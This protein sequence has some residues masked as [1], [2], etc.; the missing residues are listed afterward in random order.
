MLESGITTSHLM[1]FTYEFETQLLYI[2]SLD[3]YYRVDDQTKEL[4]K[5]RADITSNI[6]LYTL[7]KPDA[8]GSTPSLSHVQRNA[9]E[10]CF[11]GNS[12]KM[13]NLSAKEDYIIANGT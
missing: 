2:N 13:I 7:L 3:S 1:R 4:I 5:R 10:F 8:A 6:E 9:M 12:I 11:E